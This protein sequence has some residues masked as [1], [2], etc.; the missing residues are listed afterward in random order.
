MAGARTSGDGG[1]ALALPRV[2]SMGARLV[3]LVQP[4][5][6]SYG[7]PPPTRHLPAAAAAAPRRSGGARRAMGDATLTRRRP[8]G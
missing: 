5:T 6:P 2:A 4:R 1:G 8:V 3:I 7:R